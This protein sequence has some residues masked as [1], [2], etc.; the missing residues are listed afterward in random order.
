[1]KPSVPLEFD[2]DLLF[3]WLIKDGNTLEF[4]NS[5]D[6]K[7]KGDIVLEFESNPC[8]LVDNIEL[9]SGNQMRNLEINPDKI[10]QISFPVEINH[11][12][13]ITINAEFTN[14]EPCFVD[15]GDSRNFGAKLV[16]W[17]FE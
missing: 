5:S 10:T 15:N 14:K 7:I 2:K 16:S 3:W 6:E 1:M 17:S 8:K 4:H 13:S 9:K 11:K 12:S